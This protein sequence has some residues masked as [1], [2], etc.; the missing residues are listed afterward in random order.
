MGISYTR[1]A[2]RP[3][4]LDCQFIMG[5]RSK[6]CGP[7]H[8]EWR[9]FR[10]AHRHLNPGLAAPVARRGKVR[11]ACGRMAHHASSR[12]QAAART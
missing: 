12:C 5:S 2:G 6:R 11:G 1:D 4:V 8:D 10:T 3:A 7:T 9:Q